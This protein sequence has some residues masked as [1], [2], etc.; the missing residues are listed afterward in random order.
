[1]SKE[2]WPYQKD[3]CGEKKEDIISIWMVMW[4]QYIGFYKKNT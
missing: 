1:M 4:K 3:E 2:I